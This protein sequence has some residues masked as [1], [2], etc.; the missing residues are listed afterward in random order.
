M[1]VLNNFRIGADPEFIVLN[2]P[3]I[4][5][6]TPREHPSFGYDH[7]FYVIEPHPAPSLSIREVIHNL[8]ASL[9]T[10]AFYHPE[11]SKWRAGAYYIGEN[12][13]ISLGGHIHIDQPTPVPGVML[14]LDRFT[15]S[16]LALEILPNKEHEA[17]IHNTGYGALGDIRTEHGHFEYRSMPSWLFS[18]KTAML[19]M[20]GAKLLA[21]LPAE[22]PMANIASYKE[23]RAWFEKF[24][25]KDDDVDWIL[26]HA[27]FD[28]TLEA[29]PDNNLKRVWKVRP[30]APAVPTKYRIGEEGD[31]INVGLPTGGGLVNL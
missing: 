25:G 16:L 29:R 15:R 27:Y 8:R 22:R 1:Q 21:A 14:G 23:L 3:R 13:H 9:N 7:G 5:M 12:R 17:R 18:V 19:C 24:K 11:E 30:E 2:G 4:Q 10:I 28:T 31:F 26:E 6:N 20:T